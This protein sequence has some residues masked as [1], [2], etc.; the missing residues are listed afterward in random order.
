VK[1]P[2]CNGSAISYLHLWHSLDGS[3]TWKLYSNFLVSNAPFFQLNIRNLF[4]CGCQCWLVY[5]TNDH[6]IHCFSITMMVSSWIFNYKAY[7]CSLDLMCCKICFGLFTA[8]VGLT[9]PFNICVDH[10][11][12]FKWQRNH[13]GY[14]DRVINSRVYHPNNCARDRSYR[15]DCWNVHVPSFIG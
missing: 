6:M 2:L 9:S 3:M 4:I 5:C 13:C 14:W 8:Q 10:C 12:R 1:F 7:T 15:N 11:Y